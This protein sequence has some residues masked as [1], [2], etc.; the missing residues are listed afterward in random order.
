MSEIG[1]ESAA[2]AD[3]DDGDL[4]PDDRTLT[5]WPIAGAA[6][7]AALV[8]LVIVLAGPGEDN[9][10]GSKID[11]GGALV[12]PDSYEQRAFVRN[13]KIQKPWV[14][15]EPTGVGGDTTLVPDTEPS[16]VTLCQYSST[17][18]DTDN[19]V[20]VKL[21]GHRTLDSGLREVTKDLTDEPKRQSSSTGCTSSGGAKEDYLIGLRFATGLLWVSVPAN[22]CLGATN[23]KFVTG[24]SL[25]ARV[26]RAYEARAWP[27][28]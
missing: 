2:H 18:T 8:V 4:E 17:R 21:S 23:G 9:H 5:W 13:G 25:T 12:C 16:H 22:D 26:T 15:V 10:V 27:T 6:I 11:N 1:D 24:S 7:V 28:G 3:V 14:P 20:E 19:A